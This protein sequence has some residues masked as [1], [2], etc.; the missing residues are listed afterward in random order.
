MHTLSRYLERTRLLRTSSKLFIATVRPH[1]SVSK[2]T[3]GRWIKATLKM[4]GVD[5]EVFKPHSTRAGA[6]S[7]ALRKGVPV[8]DILKVAGWSKETTFACFY[9]KPIAV[10][11]D[12]DLA[13][14]ILGP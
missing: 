11:K 14:A 8:S 2:D 5:V 9:N 6:T 1:G 4:A 12:T 13:E 3:I 10:T 7:A